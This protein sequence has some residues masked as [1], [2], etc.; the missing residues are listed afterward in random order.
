MKADEPF[1]HNRLLKRVAAELLEPLG[2]YQRGRSRT[3]VDDHD[4]WAISV[5]FGPS[6]FGRGTY[7]HVGVSMLWKPDPRA[8]LAFDLDTKDRWKTPMGRFETPY[9]D[10]RRPD[11]FERDVRAFAEG[12]IDHVLALRSRS[13]DLRSLVARLDASS[14]FWHRYHRAIALGLLRDDVAAARAFSTIISEPN[15][16][17]ADWIAETQ[18]NAR[19]LSGLLLTRREFDR[20]VVS[21]IAQFREGAR[22]R[23]RSRDVVLASL[24]AAS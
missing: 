10:A 15:P 3:W 13:N 19:T 17:D 8:V 1:D 23:E 7:L 22:L 24:R 11:W 20:Q 18:E 21:Q 9:I 16:Y 2:L 6:G 12:A 4:W 14:H 5:A